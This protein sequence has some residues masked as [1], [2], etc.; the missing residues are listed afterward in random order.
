[1]G[2]APTMWSRLI[3]CMS[4]ARSTRQSM[5]LPVHWHR[6]EIPAATATES[7]IGGEPDAPERH[8]RG[9]GDSR[10]CAGFRTPGWGP[11]RADSRR[12]KTCTDS[13]VHLTGQ[14]HEQRPKAD[15]TGELRWPPSQSVPADGA[16]AA[17]LR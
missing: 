5:S 9:H 4:L 17:A 1:K 14:S 16:S 10:F 8:L 13:E 11:A 2:P 6:P 3:S 7:G 15:V 12:R